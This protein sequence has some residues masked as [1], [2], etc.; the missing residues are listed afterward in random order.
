MNYDLAVRL[1]SSSANKGNEYAQRLLENEFT[2][3]QN[4]FAVALVSLRL[5]I[6]IAQILQDDISKTDDIHSRI[7]K[8]VRRRIEEKKMAQGIKPE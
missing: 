8:K 6:R 7:E 4:N 3:S 5:L 2:Y 1:L